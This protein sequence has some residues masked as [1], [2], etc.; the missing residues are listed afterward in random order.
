MRD[1]YFKNLNL[2]VIRRDG[3]ILSEKKQV[4]LFRAFLGRR[5]RI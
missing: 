2:F 1:E 3:P 5:L 4:A